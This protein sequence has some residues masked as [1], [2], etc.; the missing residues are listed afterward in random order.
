MDIESTGNFWSKY[1][2]I[3][4]QTSAANRLKLTISSPI[5]TSLYTFTF[6]LRHGHACR[7]YL[8]RDI[9]SLQVF[10]KPFNRLLESTFFG[11]LYRRLALYVVLQNEFRDSEVKIHVDARYHREQQIHEMHPHSKCVGNQARSLQTSYLPYQ[12]KALG[13][14]H[15][16]RSY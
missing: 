14:P 7:Q 4:T 6:L 5:L 11:S 1:P 2:L 10:D 9:S 15:R 3:H 8:F 13:M 12:Q 16:P